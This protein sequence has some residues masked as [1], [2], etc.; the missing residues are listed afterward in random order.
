METNKKGRKM[1][2]Y[3]DLT[4]KHAVKI[5][6]IWD[7]TEKNDDCCVKWLISWWIKMLVETTG[8]L[9]WLIVDFL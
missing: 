4:K 5:V 3:G 2:E 1:V 8:D 7:L 6:E 9:W